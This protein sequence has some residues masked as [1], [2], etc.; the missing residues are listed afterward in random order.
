MK[1]LT[2]THNLSDLIGSYGPDWRSGVCADHE[3]MWMGRT[4]NLPSG[5]RILINHDNTFERNRF[6]LPRPSPRERRERRRME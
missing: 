6:C 3:H 1:Q 2:T 5:K 4:G